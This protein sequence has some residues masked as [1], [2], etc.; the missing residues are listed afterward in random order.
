MKDQSQAVKV[1]LFLVGIIVLVA[2]VRYLTPPSDFPTGSMVTVVEGSGLYVLAE[3]L[4]E[5]NVI[6]SPFWFRAAAILLGGER[7]MKAGQYYMERP[8]NPFFVAWRIHQGRYDVETVRLTV[9]EGF[10]IK[11]ISALFDE[12]FPFFDNA[13]FE[14]SA[15]E[16]YLFPDTYFVPVTASAS[17]T[18]KIMRDNF[19]R[20]IFPV[21]P[22]VEDSGKELEDIIIVAS[23]IEGEANNQKDREIVSGILWKRLKIGMPLQVDV[24][25]KTYEFQG[26]PK[27]P[28]NN[29]G[30]DSIRAALH[31]TSTPYL[32]YLTGDDGNMYYSKTFDEHV[33]KKQKYI[34]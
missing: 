26:L 9:P 8:Q 7:D 13:Y 33:A 21:M 23:L 32:Y 6:R 4:Q 20:K 2:A 12:R 30:L 11:K 24:E 27:S 28:I 17:S 31:P 3:N 29:P 15:P 5:Q 14:N 10:T 19:I 18:V 25:K 1:Y 34:K 22:E 16:G